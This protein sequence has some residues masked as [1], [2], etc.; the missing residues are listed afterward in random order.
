MCTCVT[1][2]HHLGS[3]PTRAKG[4]EQVR[5]CT[6]AQS[7]LTYTCMSRLP[8]YCASAEWSSLLLVC[9]KDAALYGNMFARGQLYEEEPPQGAGDSGHSDDDTFD[10]DKDRPLGRNVRRCP[11]APHLPGHER[12]RT[13]ADT[14]HG[15]FGM[16]RARE[17]G[18]CVVFAM[19][20]IQ[21]P[22]PEEVARTIRSMQHNMERAQ[23]RRP[24]P[25]AASGIW[26]PFRV[27]PWWA[28]ALIVLHLLYRIAKV[29]WAGTASLAAR[30][31]LRQ[32]LCSQRCVSC[33]CA[34]VVAD[35]RAW[36]HLGA[37]ATYARA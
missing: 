3:V 4:T 22:S 10:G 37:T 16:V 29:S 25:P 12:Q 9:R 35:P 18:V 6:V 21:D 5:Y 8:A 30:V 1:G 31:M 26:E 7:A 32:A 2:P 14:R 24:R 27:L 20:K 17:F 28:W 36:H 33:T 13:C 19:Q 34:A 11:H 23:Q 15:G